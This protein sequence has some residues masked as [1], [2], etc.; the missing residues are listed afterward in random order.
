[1]Q[2]VKKFD[3][4]KPEQPSIPGVPEAAEN[5][6]STTPAAP[7]ISS[8]HRPAA[9]SLEPQSQF[10][11]L[12]LAVVG[13]LIT[14]GGLFYWAR[15]SASKPQPRAAVEASAPPVAGAKPASAE[16]LLIGPGPIATTA[17]LSKPWSA[18]RFLF[19]DPL[20]GPNADLAIVVRL[21]GGQ[22]WGLFLREPFGDCELDYIT[23]VKKIES[24]YGYQAD[25]P[26][27]VN[28]CSHTV[29]DLMRYGSGALNGGV[30]RGDIV[31]GAGIRPPMAIQ[32]RTS[33]KEV[34][35]VRSE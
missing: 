9:R 35:A 27:V 20:G 28:P 3:P 31:Q 12:A 2:D 23:D 19:R 25:H 11:W 1:M 16:K 17:E 24:D 5:G 22:Y 34:I 15:S 10:V 21:P 6:Q 8:P 26:M 18:K 33:G 4:F 13:A 32:I 14:T 7:G 29:Y 30:V